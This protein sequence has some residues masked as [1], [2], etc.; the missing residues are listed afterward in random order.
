VGGQSTSFGAAAGE[1]DRARPEYPAE[2]VAWMLPADARDVA[3]VGAGTGK[4]TS[5]LVAEGRTVTAIDPDP[6]MLA[7][8]SERLPGIQTLVGT[9]EQLPLPDASMDAVVFGQAWHWVDPP[10]AS[11]EVARVLRSGGTLGLIWN[12][13]DEAEPWVRELTSVMH[14]SDAEQLIAAGG[15]VVGEPF[16][17]LE[18]AT[19]RW[20]A[21]FT[22]DSL[23]ELAASRSYIITATPER[24][25]EVLAGVR[26]L[27]QRVADADGHIELPYVTHVYPTRLPAG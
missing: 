16:G 9:G 10:R 13:R 22:V 12:I 5:G 19:F 3:D 24:R 2:A 1:Y 25:D 4:L 11:A 20:S 27:G 6:Q 26:S 21:S 17:P 8:L 23:V 18:H 14:T 15:P 7:R